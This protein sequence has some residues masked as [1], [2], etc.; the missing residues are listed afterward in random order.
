MLKDYL[1]SLGCF[2]DNQFL[3]EYLELV[4]QPFSNSSYSEKHHVIPVSFYITD[5]SVDR[6]LVEAI[7]LEDPNNKLVKLS[8]NDHFYA[9]WLLYKCTTGKVKS[10]NAKT[11]IAMSKKEDVINL[12]HDEIQK[13]KSE[14]KKELD[15]Y[16]SQE[17]DEFLKAHYKKLSISKI[18]KALG[19]TH[20]ATQARIVRLH[21]SDS[22]WTA[23]E[24]DWLTKNYN[25][26]GMEEAVK[27][28][29]RTSSSIE[30]KVNRLNISNRQWK[31]Y[32]TIW[33]A[34]NKDRFTVQEL[35]DKLGKSKAAIY[36]KLKSL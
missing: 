18:A 25:K 34:E 21:L 24:I 8:Y 31:E 12:S 3:D 33:L 35:A 32:E 19:K 27:Y 17:D 20:K 28:L 15:Y 36:T 30:H 2:I 29:N 26:V 13:I 23:D 1:L 16:W 7:A 4:R 6:H 9:H 22:H 5:Y 14:I 11:I 10:A